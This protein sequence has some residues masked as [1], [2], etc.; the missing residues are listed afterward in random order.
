[1]K[2]LSLWGR[3][4]LNSPS[5]LHLL[6]V[7]PFHK[8]SLLISGNIFWFIRIFFGQFYEPFL[9]YT[10]VYI[11][12]IHWYAHIY[13]VCTID[14]VQ[15]NTFIRAFFRT[16]IS[17]HPP[18][19][20]TPSTLDHRPFHEKSEAMTTSCIELLWSH[21]E[22]P[23]EPMDGSFP[24]F[25]CMWNDDFFIGR[26]TWLDERCMSQNENLFFF[27][28]WWDYLKTYHGGSFWRDAL[29]ARPGSPNTDA[30]E[31]IV[32]FRQSWLMSY[33]E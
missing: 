22:A 9:K 4:T 31:T 16:S 1:M 13:N 14:P 18:S 15:K 20:I 10:I 33:I 2:P 6:M 3:W 28:D 23:R 17:F 30:V 29:R 11:S 12:Y 5:P 21:P 7:T 27:N 25:C 26:K 32:H 19:I 24:R 8:S